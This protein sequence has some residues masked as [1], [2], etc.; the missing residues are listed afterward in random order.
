MYIPREYYVCYVRAMSKI[1]SNITCVFVNG[2]L[3]EKRCM[4]ANQTG[5]TFTVYFVT[6]LFVFFW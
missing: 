3:S 5:P 2:E 1:N 6:L 4:D